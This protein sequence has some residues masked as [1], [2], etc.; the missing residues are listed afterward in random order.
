MYAL[1]TQFS[2]RSDNLQAHSKFR[3][4]MRKTA[5]RFHSVFR[6]HLAAHGVSAERKSIYDDIEA[7]DGAAAYHELDMAPCS[8]GWGRM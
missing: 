3:A 5:L 1:R 4:A 2:M 6:G 7:R 8:T